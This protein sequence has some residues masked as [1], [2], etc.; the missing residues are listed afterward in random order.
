[1]IEVREDKKL[2]S[3][4]FEWFL[5]I[6]IN[7]LK[8]IEMITSASDKVKCQLGQQCVQMSSLKL[9][10]FKYSE[11]CYTVYRFYW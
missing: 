4:I 5:D 11:S 10:N 3:S 7:L 9:D 8:V 1:M 6:E 2:V